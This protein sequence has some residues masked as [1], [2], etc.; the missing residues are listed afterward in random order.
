MNTN[1]VI[2]LSSIRSGCKNCGLCEFCL[3]SHSNT[4][5]SQQFDL[6]IERSQKIERGQHLYHLNDPFNYVYVIH[7]GSVKTYLVM[8]NGKEQV[9]GFHLQGELLGLNSISTNFHT[10]SAIAL[11]TCS[12][13]RIPFDNLEKASREN[14][15]VQ[16]TLLHLMSAEIQHDHYQLTLISRMSAEA[17]LATFLLGLSYHY[18]NRGFSAREFHLSMTRTDIADLLG[19]AVETVSRVFSHFQEEGL[20]TV[21]RRHIYLYDIEG[22][23]AI[24]P[25]YSSRPR[26]QSNNILNHVS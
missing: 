25:A 21:E 23:A 15:A 2:D 19:L 24:S 11:E 9:T 17:R 10:E 26:L 7:S 13:C 14:P 6:A 4:K 1:S 22:L 5:K 3:P 18:H 8:A 12:I 16:H 20:L